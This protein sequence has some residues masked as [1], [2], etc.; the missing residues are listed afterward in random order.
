MD[1]SQALQALQSGRAI[2]RK[3]AQERMFER[4]FLRRDVLQLIERG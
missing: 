2:W 1:L 3:H 4:G